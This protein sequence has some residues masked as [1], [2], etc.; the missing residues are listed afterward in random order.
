MIQLLIYILG[1]VFLSGLLAMI[2]AAILSVSH[3]EVEEMITHKKWGAPALK[4][5]HKKITRAVVIIVIAT[6]TVNILGPILV[7]QKAIQ[8]YGSEVIGVITGILTFATIIFSEIIPKSL[9]AHYAPLISRVAAVPIALCVRVLYP[10]VRV[11]E[12]LTEFFQSGK[13]ALGTEEQ[14]RSLVTMGRTAGHIESDEGQLIHRAFILNDKRASD[15]MTPLKDVISTPEDATIREAA[16]KVFLHPYSRYPVFGSSIHDVKGLLLSSD[17]LE[18]LAQ[19]KDEEPAVSVLR[20][21]LVVKSSTRCD[22]LIVLFRDRHVHLAIV[23]DAL[24]TVGLVTL[25]DVLEELVGEIEDETDQ[26]D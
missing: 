24:H 4:F 9:G 12:R 17:I 15:V 13:R 11:L 26:E 3:A 2:D 21:A 7:G 18:A 23:Q 16:E 14:I 19:G 25:E 5:L 22:K 6:N 20:E 10:L 8:L 1:F